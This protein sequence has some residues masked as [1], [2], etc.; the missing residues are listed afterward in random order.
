MTYY[1]K[2]QYLAEVDENDKIIGKVEKWEAHKKGIRHRAFTLALI[3]QGQLILQH[4]RHP[5]FDGYFDL[6]LSSHPVYIGKTLQ[7]NLTAV[8]DSLEREWGVDKHEL[9]YIPVEKGIAPY[10]AKDPVGGFVENE[11]DYLY[12]SEVKKLPVPKLE[13]AYGFTLQTID[14]LKD[15]KSRFYHVLAPWVKTIL[16][17]NFL[18]E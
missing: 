1:S 2:T 5:A 6:A 10:T 9:V 16:E 14:Q 8:Y 7:D 13:Y 18:V 3:Y 4:R 17:K 12:I 11:I 15:S